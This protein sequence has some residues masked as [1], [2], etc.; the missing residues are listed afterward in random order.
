MTVTIEDLTPDGWEI[1]PVSERNGRP[2]RVLGRRAFVWD[3]TP[4][5][6]ITH[7]L[8]QKPP[9]PTVTITEAQLAEALRQ[10]CWLGGVDARG[11]FAS[12]AREADRG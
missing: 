10:G 9:P 12:L 5:P 1:V 11:L 2:W 7:V 8:V 4:S 6:E 3:V